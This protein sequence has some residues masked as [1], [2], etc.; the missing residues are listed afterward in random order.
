ML[1]WSGPGAHNLC[2]NYTTEERDI[3]CWPCR[4]VFPATSP[5]IPSVFFFC[6]CFDLLILSSLFQAL[7]M[8]GDVR[9]L[10]GST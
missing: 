7:Q 5:S 2:V 10:P 9:Q 3:M 8:P 6:L 1:R 4:Y